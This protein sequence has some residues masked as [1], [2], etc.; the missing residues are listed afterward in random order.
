MT[1]TLAFWNQIGKV[2][3][4]ENPREPNSK[5]GRTREALQ[6]KVTWVFA[7][8]IFGYMGAE[9]KLTRLLYLPFDRRNELTGHI[10][11]TWR[12]DRNVHD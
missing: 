2:Y 1:N 8:F 10:S 7:L 6:N 11:F 12:L 3:E 5:T 9:G 4:A